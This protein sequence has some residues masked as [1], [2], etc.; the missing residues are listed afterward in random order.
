MAQAWLQRGAQRQVGR[1]VP[2]EALGPHAQQREVAPETE[3]RLPE[4]QAVV[5]AVAVEEA[6]LADN[7]RGQHG[8][9]RQHEQNAYGA[10]AAQ[11]TQLRTNGVIAAQQ[12][13]PQ[14]RPQPGGDAQQQRAPAGRQQERGGHCAHQRQPDNAPPPV[15]AQR[16]PHAH[17]ER[18]QQRQRRL[19]RRVVGPYQPAHAVHLN[20]LTL[21]PARK[22]KERHQQPAAEERGHCTPH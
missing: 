3:R 9:R 17:K 8:Q 11:P 4:E 20:A 7:E 15:D 22:A 2:V 10:T 14:R 13:E 12:P 21:Q 6:R 16:Q 5:H 18:T 1:V 19:V